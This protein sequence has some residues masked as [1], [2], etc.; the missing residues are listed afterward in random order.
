MASLTVSPAP[1]Q[2]P[3]DCFLSCPFLLHTNPSDFKWKLA[4]VT[5]LFKTLNTFPSHPGRNPNTAPW[6]QGLT[7]PG[8]HP[9][10]TSPP[11]PLCLAASSHSGCAGLL[12]G[13][14]CPKIFT[15]PFSL[16][17]RLSPPVIPIQVGLSPSS[18]AQ[19]K[20][21]LIEDILDNLS[22]YFFFTSFSVSFF[23]SFFE[24]GSHYVAQPG[25]ELTVLLLSQLPEYEDY[26]HGSYLFLNDYY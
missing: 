11:G 25:L 23:H 15:Q 5:L 26:R 8:P 24:T 12:T 14:Q 20:C 3:P 17:G 1:E 6:C 2:G 10:L 16:A 4:H 19:L 9:P 18:Q 21:H 7:Q 13:A 22:T